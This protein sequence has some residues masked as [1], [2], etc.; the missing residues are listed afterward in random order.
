MKAYVYIHMCENT[1][2]RVFGGSNAA[3]APGVEL[4]IDGGRFDQVYG[5]GNG[6][7]IAANIGTGGIYILIGGGYIHQLVNGSNDSGEVMGTIISETMTDPP[8]SD[9]VIEDYFLGTNHTELYEVINATIYCGGDVMMRFVNL[10]CGSNKAQIHGNINVTIE[11]GVFEHVYGGS[12]GDLASLTTPGNHEDFESNIYGDVNL[13]ITGG[14]IGDLY[15]GCDVNGN[16]TGRINVEVF[17]A[18]NDCGL[19]IGNIYGAA[20][21]TNYVPTLEDIVNGT[22]YSPKVKI[23]KGTI[24]GP[25]NE[26]PINNP[27][28]ATTTYAG[29]VF[30]GANHGYVDSN[31]KVIVG[32]GPTNTL[33]VTIKGE[34]YGGG[35]EGDVTGSPVVV[36]VPDTHG[37]VI[38]QPEST[39]IGMIKATNGIGQNVANNSQIGEDLDVHVKAIPNVYGKKFDH[40]VVGGAGARVANTTS[41][42][43]LFTMGTAEA[44]LEAIFVNA[45]G[46]RQFNYTH[47]P[48]NGGTVKVYNGMG[49]EETNI[50]PSGSSIS[51]GAELD[52][53]A[54]PNPNGYR[55]DRWEVVSGNGT[56]ANLRAAS[57][58]FTMGSQATE[59]K[60]IFVQVTTHTLTINTAEHG[61]FTVKDGLGNTVSN[62]ASIGE[63]TVLY[64]NATPEPNTDYRFKNWTVEGTGSSV[65]NA[66]SASTTFTMGTNDSSISATFEVPS[67]PGQNPQP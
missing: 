6:E 52:I 41:A 62:G 10:Y 13:T 32:N 27:T 55:F 15:G 28:N 35:N 44:T 2:E 25:T 57:T 48:T 45:D 31:P 33:P 36:V 60:A 67:E 8:C 3:S 5:G 51:I 64:L 22:I 53:R 4:T 34:V 46:I 26:L 18:D 39:T 23:I 61:S 14:T 16:I 24:G 49:F 65:G 1:V 56:I 21:L 42:T 50:V 58:T 66:N 37:L 54:I 29:N 30:G 17:S 63:G 9:A 43:T 47:T 59:I 40:W 11:G 12:K 38:T 19:F 7:E 20:N